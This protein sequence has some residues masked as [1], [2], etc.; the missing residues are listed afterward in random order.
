MTGFDWYQA[1]R[2][3]LGQDF[4]DALDEALVRLA[5]VPGASTP[6]PGSR[7]T[8]RRGPSSSNASPYSVVLSPF[9]CGARATSSRGSGTNHVHLD[10]RRCIPGRGR[11]P[12]L[13][14]GFALAVTTTRP[15][16]SQRELEDRKIGWHHG[17]VPM[18]REL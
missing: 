16:C 14:L 12:G 5:K 3:G 13:P 15:G 18:T 4:V 8:S 9:D 1:R 7:A 11:V 10:V 17:S 2:P 6:L